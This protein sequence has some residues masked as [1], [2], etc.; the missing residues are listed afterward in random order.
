MYVFYQQKNQADKRTV[1]D[2]KELQRKLE[3]SEEECKRLKEK[4]TKTEFELQNTVEE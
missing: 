4:L 3:R 1:A 2:L